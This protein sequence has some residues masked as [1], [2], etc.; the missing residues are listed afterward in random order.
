MIN[1]SQYGTL[2]VTGSGVTEIFLEKVP[3]YLSAEPHYRIFEAFLN[4]VILFYTGFL[5]KIIV[6]LY[7]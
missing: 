2:I 3:N 7:I 6:F 5:V 1:F 4:E